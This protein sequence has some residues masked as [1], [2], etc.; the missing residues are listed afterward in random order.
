M[1]SE[2]Y[3]ATAPSRRISSDATA[4]DGIEARSGP[5]EPKDNAVSPPWKT[6]TKGRP[7]EAFAIEHDQHLVPWQAA[8]GRGANEAGRIGNGI[9]PDDKGRHDAGQGIQ[10]VSRSRIRKIGAAEH[11]DRCR[12]FRHRAAHTPRSSDN[13]FSE[14]SRANG[15]AVRRVVG[16]LLGNGHTANRERHCCCHQRYRTRPKYA[17]HVLAPHYCPAAPSVL[18]C[19]S[20]HVKQI[21][22]QVRDSVAIEPHGA[23]YGMPFNGP[24]ST[25]AR[26]GRNHPPCSNGRGDARTAGPA[27][28]PRRR[29]PRASPRNRPGSS[30]RRSRRSSRS[31]CSR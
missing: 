27:D 6:C 3:C 21:F 18:L 28:R 30:F 19:K 16:F 23:E 1:A 17:V 14:R 7:V 11:V 4:I 13:D 29:W 12:R 2:P 20:V 9:L 25:T 8:Q 26:P 10:H 15:L 22:P 24:R 31:G 5:C